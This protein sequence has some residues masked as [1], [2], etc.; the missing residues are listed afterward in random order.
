LFGDIVRNELVLNDAGIMVEKCWNEIPKHFR[1][2]T[3]DEHA[4]VPNHFLGIIMIVRAGYP[5]PY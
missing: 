2:V 5:A 1:H 4:I 3:L